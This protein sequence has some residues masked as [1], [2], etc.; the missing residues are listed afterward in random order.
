MKTSHPWD[1]KLGSIE[2][3]ELWQSFQLLPSLSSCSRPQSP[4]MII[5]FRYCP[6]CF[7]GISRGRSR[8]ECSSLPVPTSSRSSA[9]TLHH[10]L[11][12]PPF[13]IYSK[14]NL[15]IGY[16]PTRF[17]NPLLALLMLF[18]LWLTFFF[19]TAFKTPSQFNNDPSD[20]SDVSDWVSSE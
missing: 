14:P 11:H 15:I 10:L 9:T 18:L 19:G 4:K 6:R 2:D 16:S 7:T 3:G 13:Y 17:F 5:L 12:L 20:C 1:R 8:K